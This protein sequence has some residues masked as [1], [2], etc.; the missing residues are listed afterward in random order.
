M[1]TYRSNHMPILTKMEIANSAGMEYRTLLNQSMTGTM[2]LQTSMIQVAH[3]YW[4]K[5]RAQKAARS[6]SS[7]LYQAMKNSDR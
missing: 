1:I 5:R 6:T 4:P 7:P 2:P 3:Q